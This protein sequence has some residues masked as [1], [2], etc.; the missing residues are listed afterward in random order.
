VKKQARRSPGWWGTYQEYLESPAWSEKRAEVLG[1]AGHLCQR[2][3]GRKA[4]TVHHLSYAR[5]GNEGLEDLVAVCR[6]C[7]D[8]QHPDKQRKPEQEY[9]GP[10]GTC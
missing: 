6:H 5:M 8:K 2:C 10:M 1:E 4:T 7:H 9:F 3:G